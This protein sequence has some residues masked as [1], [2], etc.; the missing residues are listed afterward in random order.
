MLELN[1]IYNENCIQGMRKIPDKSIDIIVTDPPYLI[2]YKTGHRKD[3]KHRFC[4][5]IENDRPSDIGFINKF[6]CESYRALKDNTAMYCFC[7][8]KMR[9]FED[10]A[11]QNGFKIKNRIMWDKGN[12]SAG[13]LKA[14]Y[15]QQYEL[16][17]LLNKGRRVINGKRISDIWRFPRVSGGKYIKIKSL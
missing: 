3:K 14:Q 6:L 10:I 16:I 15:G 13:D 9:V 1:R 8:P 4:K 7:S 2:A 17:L 12:W 5:E 11:E